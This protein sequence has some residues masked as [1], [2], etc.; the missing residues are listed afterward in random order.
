MS[1]FLSVC[2]TESTKKCSPP[3][4]LSTFCDEILKLLWCFPSR[5]DSYVRPWRISS[6]IWS[7][8]WLNKRTQVRSCPFNNNVHTGDE[9]D[10]LSLRSG[11]SISIQQ[12]RTQLICKANKSA[13]NTKTADGRTWGD[14]KQ[15]RAATPLKS[16]HFNEF[17]SSPELLFAHIFAYG[18]FGMASEM[19]EKCDNKNS[20]TWI[21]K[22]TIFIRF[23]FSVTKHT[24]F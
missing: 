14:K 8:D 2:C 1:L 15:K 7:G 21:T 24:T 10:F 4:R 22:I 5:F 20:T 11:F 19:T 13:N 18:L 6:L 9:G 23:C 3:V 12:E 16:R 17:I